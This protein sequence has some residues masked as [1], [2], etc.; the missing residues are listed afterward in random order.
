MGNALSSGNYISH[1]SPPPQW[2]H[3]SFAPV[4][5]YMKVI[6]KKAILPIDFTFSLQESNTQQLKK[7]R[8][9]SNGFLRPKKV[10]YFCYLLIFIIISDAYGAFSLSSKEHPQTIGT[11]TFLIKNHEK[12]KKVLVLGKKTFLNKI[13]I[14]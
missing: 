10:Y 8:K 3:H 7:L 14:A 6:Y 5:L 13:Y 4:F 9:F 2:K 12:V 11:H 1:P